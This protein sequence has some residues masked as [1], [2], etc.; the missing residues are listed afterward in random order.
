MKLSLKATSIVEAIIVLLIVVS[1]ITWIYTL[2]TSSQKLAASTWNRIEA[3]QIARD[4][5]EAF[6]NIR[7]TNWILYSADNENCWNTINYNNT[8]IWNSTDK[9]I[10]I[11]WANV[12]ATGNKRRYLIYKNTS[13]QWVLNEATNSPAWF[14]YKNSTV[15]SDY[16]EVFR[17]GKDW[18]WFYSQWPWIVEDFTPTYTRSISLDYID[19]DANWVDEITIDDKII[20]TTLVEWIDSSSSSP[21]KVEMSTVLTNWKAKK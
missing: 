7:D 8:C 16:R 3:I 1:G 4:G 19:T 17:V 21:Q 13:Q 2:L 20:V 12:G 15:G 6:T 9:T 11:R 10:R 18:N 14:N 5:L